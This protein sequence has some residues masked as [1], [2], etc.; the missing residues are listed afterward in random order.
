MLASLDETIGLAR[1]PVIHA[2]DSRSPLG[3]RRDRHEHIGKGGIGLEGFRRI[4]N[5]P[6]LRDKTFILETPLEAEG[7]DRRNMAAIRSV[8]E[9]EN[10]DNQARARRKNSNP[11]RRIAPT[12]SVR[13][14][15]LRTI[16]P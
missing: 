2:N 4:V 12:T 13:A 11:A 16:R 9:A 3:S 10:F 7:D 6:S 15:K 5:H 8:R 14:V 1:V